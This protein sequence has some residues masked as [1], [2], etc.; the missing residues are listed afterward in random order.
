MPLLLPQPTN[1]RVAQAD[2][3]VRQI[4]TAAPIT[5][6]S[7]PSAYLMR[8]MD[9]RVAA[10]TDPLIPFLALVRIL[11]FLPER[12]ADRQYAA[13]VFLHDTPIAHWTPR[14]RVFLPKVIV[15]LESLHAL[16][17]AEPPPDRDTF[18][19]RARLLADPLVNPPGL[20][21]LS[22]D[23]LTSYRAAYRALLDRIETGA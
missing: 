23:E 17:F 21:R 6:N 1:D 19:A 3:I 5:L 12:R 10:T 22:L 8:L 2:V 7:P 16:A 9:A 13:L 20:D 14:L 11:T 4:E 18:T 15:A